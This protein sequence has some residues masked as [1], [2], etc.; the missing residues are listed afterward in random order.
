MNLSDLVT[1]ATKNKKNVNEFLLKD[2]VGKKDRQSDILPVDE[3]LAWHHSSATTALWSGGFDVQLFAEGY[4]GT[5]NITS[6][7]IRIIYHLLF[8]KENIL[9][10]GT[11]NDVINALFQVSAS[12]IMNAPSSPDSSPVVSFVC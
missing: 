8:T 10:T 11:V 7:I 4:V 5:K 9:T 12:N 3:D 2:K 1:S 6:R